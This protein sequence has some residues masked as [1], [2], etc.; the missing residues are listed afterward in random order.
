[1]KKGSVVSAFLFVCMFFLGGAAAAQ[2]VLPGYDGFWNRNTKISALDILAFYPDRIPY[3]RN[4]I[5]ARYGRPFVNQEY[6]AYFNGRHWYRIRSNYTDAWISEAD[7]YNAELLKAMEQAPSVAETLDIIVDKVEYGSAEYILSFSRYTAIE[8]E[9][10]GYFATYGRNYDED[11]NWPY[12]ITGDWV[13]LYRRESSG[14]SSVYHAKACRLNHTNRTITVRAEGYV[15][16][17]VL[18]PLIAAQSRRDTGR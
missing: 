18:D 5:Y 9:A 12:I 3:L 16:D 6:Q 15:M 2:S 13:I 1:M 11:A 4:E 8:G 10:D 17:T 14:P 7:K